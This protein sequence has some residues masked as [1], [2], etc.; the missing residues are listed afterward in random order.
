MEELQDLL[1]RL[2]GLLKPQYLMDAGM[3]GLLD[4]LIHV[5]CPSGTPLSA[6]L[7][8]RLRGIPDQIARFKE[9]A[10][11]TGATDGASLQ[12]LVRNLRVSGLMKHQ[13]G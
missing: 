1:A 6:E 11:E 10:Q 13:N 4:Q 5:L 2:V 3:A 12:R 9:A 8:E 7:I